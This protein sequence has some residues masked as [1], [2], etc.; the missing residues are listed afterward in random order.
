[1]TKT[2]STVMLII[3]IAVLAF[4]GVFTFIPEFEYG[5]YGEFYSPST[6]IQ[7]SNLFSNTLTTTYS[8]ELEDGVTAQSV[9]KNINKRLS[10]IYGIYGADIL[11]KD[12]VLTV[13]IPEIANNS[14]GLTAD[15]VMKVV[16]ASGVLEIVTSTTYSDDSV[17]LSA[18][19]FKSASTRK[20]VSQG[21]EYYV[22]IV[23]LTTEG[24]KAAKSLS[25]IYAAVD[26]TV[27]YGAQLYTEN[28]LYL[29]GSSI[30]DAKQIAGYVNCGALNAELEF[31]DS[32][33]NES[34]GGLFLLI[35]IAVVVLALAVF[36]IVRYK[37]LGWV[38]VLSQLFSIVVAT[39]VAG[40]I[41]LEILNLFGVIGLLLGIALQTYFTVYAFDNINAYEGSTFA[42]AKHKGFA[43]SNKLNLIVHG[44][45]L[46]VGI[47]LWVI[48][49]I[50]TA[51]LGNVLVY[52]AVL[53]FIATMGLNRLLAQIFEPFIEGAKSNRK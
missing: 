50:V 19:H 34:L 43:K 38:A 23:H 48:P 33:T 35:G 24:A 44:T 29:F 3:F 16:S 10:A 47:I 18:E 30:L 53:S 12:N 2:A 20:L 6:L 27:A 41:H 51:P 4:V 15:S 28:T 14:D 5:A 7:K 37:T 36:Y 31:S 46:V 11:L 1:M 8:V 21:T 52:L 25:T 22:A 26:G 9:Q 45:A 40:L 42:S 32:A 39:I 17:V 49:T 13:T